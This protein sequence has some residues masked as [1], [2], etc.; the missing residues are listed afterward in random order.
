MTRAQTGPAAAARHDAGRRTLLTF[1]LQ[2]EVFA[3]GVEHVSEVIDPLPTTRV[4]GAGALVPALVNVRGSVVPVMSLHHRLGATE[5]ER[6]EETR[7]IVLTA[8]LGEERVKLAVTADRVD[9]VLEIGAEDIE[10]V[11]EIGIGWPSRLLE[12]VAKREEALVIL[13]E[14]EALFAPAGARGTQAAAPGCDG[15]AT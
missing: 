9:R 10:P 4:P 7:M 6:T 2:G 15:R 3:L 5:A 12:G 11:P 1:A 13:L 8:S 14:P